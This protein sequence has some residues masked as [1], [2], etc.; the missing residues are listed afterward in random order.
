[1]SEDKT[2]RPT[3]GRSSSGIGSW[4][5]RYAVAVAVIGLAAGL[6]IWP[7]GALESRIAWVTFY[8]AVMAAALYGGFSPGLLATILSDLV[9]LLWSP[10][11]EPFIDDP[12]DWLGLAVFSANGTLIALMSEAMHRARGRATRA[13]AQAEAANRAKSVFLANMSHELRTP[14]NAILG[15]S[16]LLKRDPDTTTDQQETLGIINR[17]GAHLLSMIN[18]VLDLSKIEAGRQEPVLGAFDLLQMLEDIGRMF[19][20]R[21]E[22]AQLGFE[23][24]L[25]P[26]LARYVTTDIGKLRQI[27]IN[28]LGNAIKFTSEGGVSLRVRTLPMADDPSMLT[29]QVEVEDS[30][31]GIMPEQQARIF[32]PFVQVQQVSSSLKGTGL[33][34]AISKTFVELLGGEIRVE[35]TPGTGS[36]FR[37]DLPVGLAEADEVGG[38]DAAK[39]AVLGLESGQP[40]WRILVVEDNPDSRLLLRRLLAEAGFEVRVA[41]DGQEGVALFERWRPHFIWMDIQMPVM[42]GYEATRHIRTS[43]GGETVKIVALTASVFE[44]ERGGILEVGCDDV[45]H[46]PFRVR[47]IFDALEQHLGVRYR[48]EEIVEEAIHEPVEVS[49]EAIA[50]LPNDLRET[51]RVASVSLDND[52]FA[53]VLAPIR[54]RDPALATGLAALAREFRFDRILTLIGTQEHTVS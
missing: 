3:L 7:L 44:E 26:A 13:R 16:D 20:V 36:L 12:G 35:S 39:P 18:D 47:E 6:R 29:L 8:P 11:D 38:V 32:A 17:S 23:L 21:A 37:I 46:K 40:A 41:K 15:F 27:L 53:A 31:P 33:G 9:V 10:T 45:M 34:L 43:P 24:E 25:D 1:M 50:A 5:I 4:V 48:Y 30:G 2:D 52:A 54:E 14:L 19:K 28:L 42:N 22:S 49:A 51:L